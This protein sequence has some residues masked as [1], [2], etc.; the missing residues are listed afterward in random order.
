MS[1]STKL[2]SKNFRTWLRRIDRGE[3]STASIRLLVGIAAGTTS[4][5]TSLTSEEAN[6]ICEEIARIGGIK[7][8]AADEAAGLAWV[9]RWGVKRLGLSPEFVRGADR[10]TF[11]GQYR[12]FSD[13]CTLPVWTLHGSGTYES[14]SA[15]YWAASWQARTWGS[16]HTSNADEA[17]WW[18]DCGE[19]PS[20]TSGSATT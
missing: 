1:T 15:R 5:R 9:R 10:F 16:G 20:T 17:W 11:E 12:V 13:Q 4:K 3:A 7:L 14:W 8:T 2:P 6:L 19:R 18:V